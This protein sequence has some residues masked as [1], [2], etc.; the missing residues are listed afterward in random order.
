MFLEIK[1]DERGREREREREREK[2]RE[3]KL[4]REGG[5]RENEIRERERERERDE[6]LCFLC[7]SYG[8]YFSHE[9]KSSCGLYVFIKGEWRQIRT[10]SPFQT[11]ISN[12]LENMGAPSH[13]Y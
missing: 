6:C 7:S 11:G 2:E 4:E 12:N 10:L 9:K 1:G 5:E 13:C 8:S 3:R